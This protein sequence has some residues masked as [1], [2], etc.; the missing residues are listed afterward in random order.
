MDPIVLH[1]GGI[2]SLAR[3]ESRPSILVDIDGSRST[4]DDCIHGSPIL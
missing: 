4:D 1:S 3:I 2:K